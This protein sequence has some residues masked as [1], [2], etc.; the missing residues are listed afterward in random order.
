[1][2]PDPPACRALLQQRVGYLLLLVVEVLRES[3]LADELLKRDARCAVQLVQRRSAVHH[4][5]Q[6]L[7]AALSG[8]FWR[9]F[10]HLA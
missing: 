7:L 8:H 4:V 5:A 9:M 2:S 1:M 10:S 3:R 6:D